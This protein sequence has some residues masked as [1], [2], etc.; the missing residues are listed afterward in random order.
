MKIALAGLAGVAAAWLLPRGGVT[1]APTPSLAPSDRPGVT[2][3]TIPL[4]TIQMGVT[5][6]LIG[7]TRVFLVRTGDAVTAFV[8]RSSEVGD[9]PVWWCPRNGWFESPGLASAY[10]RD[11][12]AMFGSQRGLD[13]IR[14]LVS[15]GSVT[16]F[17]SNVTKGP[18]PPKPGSRPRSALQC[19]ASERVG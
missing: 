12:D 7:T 14:V 9:G 16:V 8:G 19:A 15:A 10:S 2:A 13:R 6:R 18:A 5:Y 3:V 1:P 4:A 11:G 17:P